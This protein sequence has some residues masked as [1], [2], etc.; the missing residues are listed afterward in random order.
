[1]NMR[2]LFL[3]S[4]VSILLVGGATHV[5]ATHDLGVLEKKI[6]QQK[7]QNTTKKPIPTQVKK[8]VTK[9]TTQPIVKKVTPVNK[10]APQKT[11]SVKK[12]PATPVKKVVKKPA[13][14]AKQELASE[15]VEVKTKPVTSTVPATK[16]EDVTKQ[17]IEK[18]LSESKKQIEEITRSAKQTFLEEMLSH[19]QFLKTQADTVMAKIQKNPHEPEYLEN[20]RKQ[21]GISELQDQF[22]K[23]Q[24]QV[25]G[26][27]KDI[28][29]LP[30]NTPNVDI[31][32]SLSLQKMKFE[33][34]QKQE[35]ILQQI[36]LKENFVKQYWE[37]QKGEYDF[38]SKLY[39]SLAQKFIAAQT[40]IKKLEQEIGVVQK[41]EPQKQ[42]SLKTT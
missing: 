37:S 13:V 5:F 35:S 1:M 4:L 6:E 7:K 34:L 21:N 40:L 31:S 42:S 28:R 30:Q 26:I 39:N 24:D 22:K 18:Q 10:T 23:L 25:D 33:L 32:K 14:S 29:A 11:T 15:V 2:N 20:L 36:E 27:E 12:Q 38:N 16:K 17:S 9:T 41:S 3:L 8:S 19:S